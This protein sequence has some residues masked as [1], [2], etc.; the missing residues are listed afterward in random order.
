[1][2]SGGTLADITIVDANVLVAVADR[3]SEHHRAC[4]DA[5]TA[6]E[7]VVIPALCVAEATYLI[8]RDL[9]LT[10]EARFLS[11]MSEFEVIAPEGEEWER[12]SEIVQEYEHF[13][14]GG[15]DAS[16][17]ALAERLD[18]DLIITLDRRHFHAIRP[19]HCEFFRLLPE[20]P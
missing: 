10:A 4:L 11:G 2:T 16:I 8:H 14:I 20:L 1:M 18:T 5:L 7:G 13:K 17:V 3:S 19:R 6:A 12:I 15:T 9:G